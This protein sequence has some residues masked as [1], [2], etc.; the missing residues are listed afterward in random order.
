MLPGL[1]GP[2]SKLPKWPDG[3]GHSWEGSPEKPSPPFSCPQAVHE[4]MNCKQYQDQLQLQAQDDAA[5]R[6]TSN[7]L[8]GSGG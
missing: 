3:R 4:G 2:N 5:A 8:K 6:E 1:L 7:M